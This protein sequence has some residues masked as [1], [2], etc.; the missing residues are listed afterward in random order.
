MKKQYG[1]FKVKLYRYH[2]EPTEGGLKMSINYKWF[3]E[4]GWLVR[5]IP[6]QTIRD[7]SGPGSNDEA[8][9]YW[10][11]KLNF[12]IPQQLRQKAKEY[13]AGFGAWDD[14]ELDAWVSTEDTEHELAR[15]ILWIFCGDIRDGVE[16]DSLCLDH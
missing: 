4:H 14:A 12:Y 8:V 7:C 10:L 9:E 15:R 5:E 3:D 6:E 1:E 16:W 11:H 13:L 2:G